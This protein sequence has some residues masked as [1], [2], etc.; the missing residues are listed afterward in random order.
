A[1]AGRPLRIL[2]IIPTLGVGGTERQLVKLLLRMDP[3]RT[4]HTVC[5]YTRTAN[6][7]A[8]L[9]AAGI[10]TI[11]F[12]KFA[13]KP[14]SF[15]AQLRRAVRETRPDLVHT[16]LYS[17]NV[18]GR[19]AA[20]SCGVRRLVASD[21]AMAVRLPGAVRLYERM[22]APFTLRL[23]NSRAAATSQVEAYGLP[24]ARVRVV[25]NAVDAAVLPPGARDA[26]RA[27]LGLPPGQRLVLLVA[28]QSPEK[29]HAMFFRAARRVAAARSDVTFVAV[30]HLVDPG[31]MQ[32]LL[33]ASGAGA[34]VRLV[35][36]QADIPR[37][38]AAADVFCL[39]SDREGLPNAL[40]EAM[41]AGLPVV[42]TRF[43]SATEVLS[44]DRLGVLV[45][46]DDDASL[47]AGILA[48]LGDEGRR[49]AMGRAAREHVAAAYGWD[50]LVREM[51]AIYAGLDPRRPRTGGAADRAGA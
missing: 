6:L 39:T 51:D 37:W 17:G 29:N 22:L 12:D 3:A 50:R 46:R 30:G 32:R 8:E 38:L 23:V 41:A 27:A 43:P 44:S 1:E 19:L 31:A 49:Q 20:L 33:D 11:F 21:R 40:L 16:W 35:G 14:W 47:A 36:E 24:A 26:V 48:L 25:A 15:F 13:M 5:Y 10:R 34:S 4:R 2:H 18:W 7:E 42:C 9:R 28:R 45:A